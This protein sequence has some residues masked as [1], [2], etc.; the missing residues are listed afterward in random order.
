[1]SETVHSFCRICESLCGLELSREG[2]TCE[3]DG[4]ALIGP[5]M[6]LF[7]VQVRGGLLAGWIYVLHLAAET[8][9]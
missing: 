3:S 6:A 4:Y 2:V 7:L 8:R 9:Q 1:M 5:S